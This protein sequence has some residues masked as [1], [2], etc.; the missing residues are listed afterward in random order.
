MACECFPGR[1]K[2]AFISA[3]SY[4]SHRFTLATIIISP[5]SIDSHLL[6][7]HG[8]STTAS[9]C[10][11]VRIKSDVVWLVPFGVSCPRNIRAQALLCGRYQTCI[12]LPCI[13]ASVIMLHN[14]MALA[15]STLAYLSRAWIG[16]MVSCNASSGNVACPL[17]AVTSVCFYP[18]SHLSWSRCISRQGCDTEGS[19]PR[20]S[21]SKE[22]P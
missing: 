20:Y 15:L 8:A 12:I 13:N 16:Y 18:D 21:G 19:P 3:Q 14:S 22:V 10:W 17:A 11:A 2:D 6:C 7:V 1:K 5:T 9:V 4:P